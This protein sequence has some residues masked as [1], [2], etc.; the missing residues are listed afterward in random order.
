MSSAL[1]FIPHYTVK[2]YC[3]W[4]GDWELWEGIAVAMTPSPSGRHQRVL[5]SLATMLHNAIR[6][7]ECNA[8]ALGELDWIISDDMVVRPDVIVV[9]GDPP[10]RYLRQ[11]PALIAEVLSESS[12]QIDVSFK[13]DLYQRQGVPEYLVIDP[14]AET[15]QRHQL[16][17]DGIY[18]ATT[19]SDAFALQVCDDCQIEIKVS[20]VFQR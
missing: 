6:Q 3:Q 9:C 16:A 1:K 19:P 7:A 2:E 4:Q 5:F 18:Q 11:S 8:T 12:R 14:D 17:A 20:S 10:D 13:R 15:I